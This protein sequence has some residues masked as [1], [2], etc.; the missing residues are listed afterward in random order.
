M[1]ISRTP[2]PLGGFDS[3]SDALAGTAEPDIDLSYER[4]IAPLQRR[5]FREIYSNRSMDPRTRAQ[6]ASGISAQLGS[7][8]EQQAKLR[9]IDAQRRARELSYKTGLFSLEQA[10]EKAVKE[11][12]MFEAMPAVSQQLDGIINDPTKTPE[13]KQQEVARWG[14]ANAGLLATNDA[15]KIAYNSAAAGIVKQPNPI[16]D[17]DLLRMGVP[18][19]ELDTNKDGV[20]SNE[21]RTPIGISSVLQKV[22]L[23]SQAAKAQLQYDKELRAQ[24]RGAI[25][26]T[27]RGLSS[28]KFEMTKPLIEGEAPQELDKFKDSAS[29]AA[30]N[31]A[32]TLF[33]GPRMAEEAKKLTPKKRFEIANEL[34]TNY[35]GSLVSPQSQRPSARSPFSE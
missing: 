20:V 1:P 13:L 32:I 25:D 3:G 27:L 10:R 7:A 11:R 14:V 16:T 17:E 15:A 9:D 12:R 29:E 4:D 24:Q 21:E 35:L 23:G 30:V 8:F 26:A 5:F 22:Q 31:S 33:G 2:Q 19:S 28:V 6:F 18:L 34:R